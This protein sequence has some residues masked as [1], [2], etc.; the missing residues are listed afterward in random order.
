L[1]S[2]DIRSEAGTNA[3]PV[4]CIMPEYVQVLISDP[5]LTVA[6]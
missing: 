1:A 4:D 6:E 3:S 2:T 5:Q